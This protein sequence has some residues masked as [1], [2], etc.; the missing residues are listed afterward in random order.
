MYA[1]KKSVSIKVVVLL[2]AVVLLIGCVAGGTLAYL[3][4]KSATV[5]NTFVAGNIGTL[6][7][8]ETDGEGNAVTTRSFIVTPGVNITKDPVVTFNGNNVD[9]FVFVEVTATGWTLN[10]T[11]Y[12]IGNEMSWT[13]DSAWAVLDATNYPG[14]FY[15]AVAT[16]DTDREWD[17]I[18]GDTITV[19]SEITKANIS[20]YTKELNFTAYAIQ[21]EDGGSDN[22]GKF[23]PAE[24]WT[25]AQNAT[26]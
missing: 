25:Q 6:T 15:K 22:D 7:L 4:T 12:S 10:G 19:S 16:S 5:T 8:N 11:T 14:V 13:V 21:Q 3:M 26:N 1:K 18:S 9:A 24:A 23:T 17:I 20:N 2:L